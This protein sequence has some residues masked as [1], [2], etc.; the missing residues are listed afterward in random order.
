MSQSQPTTLR[1]NAERLRADF[2][3]LSA[4]GATP[5]G[6]VHRPALSPAHLAAR[7]WFRERIT[8][9]GL[10]LRIDGAGNHSA[11]LPS[12]SPNAP[13]LLL[14]SHLDSVPNGGRFDGA[15][16]VLC[17]LEVLR[18]LQDAGRFLPVDLEAIDLTDEEGAHLG[19]LGSRAI[20]GLLAKEDL[21]HLLENPASAEALNH[22]GLTVEGILSARRKADSLAG[23]LEVHIEQGSRLEQAGTE[24]GAVTGIVGIRWHRLSFIGR[25]DHAGTTPMEDRRDAAQGASAFALAARQIVLDRFPGCVANVGRMTFSPGA[26]NVV[27]AT[28]QVALEHRAPDP[29]RLEEME[30]VLLSEAR[31]RAERFGLELAVK[32]LEAINPMPMDAGMQETIHRAAE[33]LGLSHVS[34]PSG[35]GHDAQSLARLCPAGMIFVPSVGGRSHSGQEYTEWQDCVNGANVML[36]SV[37]ELCQK[38]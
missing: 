15:L 21:D 30:Q 12:A 31:T 10:E 7:G 28:V 33:D 2:E 35:A 20:A 24:I 14:G 23:Y 37:L 16:G 1:V 17:A 4:I 22:T 18:T 9:A 6:G 38:S 27:P 19:L 36:H 26:F 25:A 32:R 8:S 13:T 34:L 5:E 3:A 29:D 11:R